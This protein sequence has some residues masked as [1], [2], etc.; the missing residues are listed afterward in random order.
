MTETKTFKCPSCGAPLAYDGA[1]AKLTCAHCGAEI[2]PD[3]FLDEE[4]FDESAPRSWDKYGDGKADWSDS[5]VTL[6]TCE[7][8]GGAEYQII[9]EATGHHYEDGVCTNCGAEDPNASKP[10]SIFDKIKDWLGGWFG[11][12]EPEEPTE[13]SVPEEDTTVPSE[14][15]EP[16]EPSKPGWGG[17]FDWFWPFR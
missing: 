7:S 6:F 3:A 9:L 17:W 11:K 5:D 8:C 15:S 4:D 13:P 12:D 10:G 2:E 14:P 1:D 16:S